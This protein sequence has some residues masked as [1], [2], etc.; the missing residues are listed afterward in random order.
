MK[1][2][3][4]DQPVV[5]AAVGTKTCFIAQRA[6]QRQF[7]NE[8]RRAR[9]MPVANSMTNYRKDLRLEKHRVCQNCLTLSRILLFLAK[10]ENVAQFVPRTV[11]AN[12]A[13][14]G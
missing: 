9:T 12:S 11:T 8:A 4:L 5:V 10:I 14:Y 1:S 3:Q 13:Q 6:A 2:G 7:T